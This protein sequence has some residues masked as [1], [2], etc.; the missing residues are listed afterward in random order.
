[1]AEENPESLGVENLSVHEKSPQPQQK[2]Q[3]VVK[4]DI[5]LNATGSAPILKQKKWSVDQE[6][7]INWVAK[8]VHKYLKLTSEE[9]LV[10]LFSVSLENDSWLL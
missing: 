7:T 4:I 1:M 5:L 2:N 8:F 9:Q 6:K 10:R 3:E